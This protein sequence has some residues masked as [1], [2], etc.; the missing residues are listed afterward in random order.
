LQ[1]NRNLKISGPATFGF[2]ITMVIMTGPFSITAVESKSSFSTSTHY[3]KLSY[4]IS[5]NNNLSSDESNI[6]SAIAVHNSS[7]SNT[8]T[9]S[10]S[11]NS[12]S[13]HKIVMINFD[14]GYKSQI[15][16]AKPILDKYGFKA[17]F[18]IVFGKVATQPSWLNWQDIALLKKDGMDIETH[19][20]THAHLNTLAKMPDQ[21]SYEIAGSNNVLLATDIMLRSLA[22]LITWDQIPH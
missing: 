14:D 1:K 9:S 4:S 2:V 15:I 19:T 16:Y 3:D 13:I 8:N 10:S 7:N 6:L 5:N 11:N 21:L 20:M 17:S 12:G 22:I 18:F